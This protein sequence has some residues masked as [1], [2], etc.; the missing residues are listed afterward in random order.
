M[1]STYPAEH[2]PFP[3]LHGDFTTRMTT[4][5]AWRCREVEHLKPYLPDEPIQN[6]ERG[7]RHEIVH[8]HPDLA[9]L[10][11][12]QKIAIAAPGECYFGAHLDSPTAVH[13][14][15]D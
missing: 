3:D 1:T 15:T 5:Y 14:Y 11:K 4:A 13:L 12:D 7:D 8:L 9:G 10:T 6:V 2:A